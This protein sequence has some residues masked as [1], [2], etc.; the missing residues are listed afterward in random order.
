MRKTPTALRWIACLCAALSTTGCERWLVR[1]Q[2]VDVPRQ[3]FVAIPP[4]LTAPTPAPPPPPME[5]VADDGQPTMCGK[6]LRQWIDYGWAQK[7]R[8]ANRDKLLIR[9]LEATAVSGAVPA[10]CK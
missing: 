10:E 2:T 6:A 1:T 3:Q 9:C 7:L 8:D 5:C 4:I